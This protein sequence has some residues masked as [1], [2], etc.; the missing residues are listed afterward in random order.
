MDG[1]RARLSYI[2]NLPKMV[3]KR[4][5]TRLLK[6]VNNIK[7]HSMKLQNHWW[8]MEADQEQAGNPVNP[9]SEPC[10][11]LAVR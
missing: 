2:V 7:L 10:D 5:Q 9:S 6:T 1:R 3:Q 11:Q 8:L 4:L